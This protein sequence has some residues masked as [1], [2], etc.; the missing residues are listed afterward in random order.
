LY[1]VGRCNWNTPKHLARFDF[2]SPQASPGEPRPSQLHLSV[3]PPSP[4]AM[5]P[6]FSVT[7]QPF[8]YLPGIPFNN[9]WAPSYFAT[10][11]L[12]PLPAA[13]LAPAEA[14][15]EDEEQAESIYAAGTDEWC[16]F[17]VMM[18]T[19]KARCY[20]IKLHTHEE[21]SSKETEAK[22]WWPQGSDWKP[23]AVGLCLE[24]ADLL[25]T[26]GK[27]WQ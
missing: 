11:A 4:S 24:D 15:I 17:Q 6:F 21:G 14:W 9:A 18:K 16:E 3:Y 23:W 5:V 13:M 7:L 22:K 26:E 27:K 10:L 2:S 12:P 20:W 1:I 25:V 19:K 8:S